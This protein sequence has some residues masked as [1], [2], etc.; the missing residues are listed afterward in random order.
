MGYLRTELGGYSF[1]REGIST[2]PYQRTD[3][4][5]TEL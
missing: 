4:F 5:E 1:P 3:R 2:Q